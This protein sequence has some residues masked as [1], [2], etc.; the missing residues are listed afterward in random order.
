MK[1]TSNLTKSMKLTIMGLVGKT[2]STSPY[3]WKT[4]PTGYVLEN[5]FSV[6]DLTNSSSGDAILFMPGFFSPTDINR[7]MFGI[8]INHML[9]AN[10]FYD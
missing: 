10:M 2:Q 4:T 3:N 9:K 5:T 1:L 8:K 6:A 7:T